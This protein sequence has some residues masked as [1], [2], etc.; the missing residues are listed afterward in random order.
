VLWLWLVGACCVLI[1]IISVSKLKIKVNLNHVRDNDF[2]QIKCSLWFGLIRYTYKIPV[3]KVDKDSSTLVVN[4]ETDAGNTSQEKGAQ[5]TWKDYSAQDMTHFLEEAKRFLEHVK[6]FHQILKGFL[7]HVSIERIRWST[8]IGTG[9]AMYTGMAAGAVWSFKG[10]VIGICSQYMK[11]KD[12]PVLEVLPS[13]QG[14]VSE[15]RFQCMI[16]FRIGHAILTS[17]RILKHWKKFS[18]K[19]TEYLRNIQSEE[20]HSAKM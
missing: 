3:V 10:T 13:F 20:I 16:S 15:T 17:L 5:D 12:R 4:E 9:D 7:S 1:F 8:V 6:G 18:S 11:L 2:Y 14:A 19:R